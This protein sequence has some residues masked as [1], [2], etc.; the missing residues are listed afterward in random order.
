[1]KKGQAKKTPNR[2]NSPDLVTLVKTFLRRTK[3]TFVCKPAQR[4]TPVPRVDVEVQ[5]IE[6]TMSKKF[7]KM[8]NLLHPS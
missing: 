3:S 2:E 1:L 5:N 7:L 4:S 8:S 6:I